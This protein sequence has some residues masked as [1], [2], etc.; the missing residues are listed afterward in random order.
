MKLVQLP[1]EATHELRRRVLYGH[2]PGAPLRYPNDESEDTFH[3]G[4]ADDGG[5]LIAVGT[6]LPEPAP[7]SPGR[8]AYRLRGMAVDER[9]R[10]RGVGRRLFD[11]G[12]AEARARA[13][14][15]LWANS[16]DTALG[17]YRRM[18]MKA[19]GEGF[20]AAGGLPHHVVLYE[21]TPSSS[22]DRLPPRSGTQPAGPVREPGSP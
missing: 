15:L 8:R 22:M 6:W 16:R 7:P 20:T 14:E 17:F 18:G 12:V 3:L 21:L 5:E 9:W 13:A 1:P 11:A 2:W 10:G 4:V 19:V